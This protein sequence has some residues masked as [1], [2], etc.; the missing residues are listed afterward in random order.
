M[1]TPSED[2]A[3]HLAMLVE[4]GLSPSHP[5][6]D[7]AMRA[8][9]CPEGCTTDPDGDCPHGWTSAARTLGVI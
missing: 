5:E 6:A 9:D 1:S 4:S 3:E 8:T 7:E 2:A